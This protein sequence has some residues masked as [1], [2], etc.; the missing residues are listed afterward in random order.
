MK[1]LFVYLW[2]GQEGT[3]RSYQREL[4]RFLSWVAEQAV[5]VIVQEAFAVVDQA[6]RA[7]EPLP[8]EQYQVVCGAAALLAYVALSEEQGFVSLGLFFRSVP[9]LFQIDWSLSLERVE[10]G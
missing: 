3:V 9:G 2:P 4:E 6:V 10:V 1:S 7:C 8:F 5:V